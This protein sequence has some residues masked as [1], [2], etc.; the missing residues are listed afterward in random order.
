MAEIDK[1]GG[2]S[3][4]GVLKVAAWAAPA[5]AVAVSAPL[6]S[7]SGFDTPTAYVTGTLT[8]RQ[9]Q[10]SRTAVYSGG[11]LTFDSAGNPS[12]DSGN[13]TI[14]LNNSRASYTVNVAEVEAAYQAKGWVLVSGSNSSIVFT[15]PPVSNGGLIEMP[16]VT[17]TAPAGTAKPLVSI[18][19]E[20]DS[21]DVSGQGLST[22]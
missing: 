21:D 3:R 15:H 19:V 6:A 18:V 20:S 7:A 1:A 16:G 12:I 11:A 14:Y 2:V 17:W 13:I 10:T 22:N 8:A 4:R 5:V 9:S